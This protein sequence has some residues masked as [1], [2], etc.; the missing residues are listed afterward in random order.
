MINLGI[1]SLEHPHSR[2]NH[3]PALRYMKDRITVKAI[4]NE[5]EELA[6]PYVEEFGARYYSERDELLRDPEIDAVLITSTNDRHAE[7]AI[8]AANHGKDIFGD[9][10]VIISFEDGERL[11]EAVKRNGVRY[12]T[13][14]PVRFNDAVLETKRAIDAGEFGKILAVVGTNHGSMYEPGCPDW[15]K[16]PKKN[17]GG[18]IIDHTVHVAD[19]MRWFTGEDFVSVYAEAKR[20][21]HGDIVAEDIAVM[22]GKM[23]GGAVFHID[24]SWSRRPKNPMWGDVT[25]RVVGEKKSAWLDIYNNQRLEFYC[26]GEFEMHYPNLV[27]KE[28]GDIFDDYIDFKEKGVPMIGAS[29]TDGVRAVELALA[30]YE[31]VRIGDAVKVERC[32]D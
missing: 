10:P 22:H 24:A 5:T 4:F 2:G 25:I 18:C 32:K 16:D 31:S 7:D 26:D 8:A 15:V 3:I 20:A 13:T 19:I 28:H 27:A 21:L 29:A 9:K 11:L 6:R 17:G 14:F 12:M 1:L 30:A 23:S